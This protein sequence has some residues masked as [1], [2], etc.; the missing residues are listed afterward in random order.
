MICF[1][2]KIILHQLIFLKPIEKANESKE[3]TAP[4]HCDHPGAKPIPYLKEYIEI[5]DAPTTQ[6]HYPVSRQTSRIN[7][8]IR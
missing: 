4:Q 6:P 2:I 5:N 3:G 7:G 8:T 1:K